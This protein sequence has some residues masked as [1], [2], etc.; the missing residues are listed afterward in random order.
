MTR[1]APTLALIGV[2][3]IWGSTFVVVKDAVEKMPVTD[4]LTWRFALASLAMLLIRPR[5]VARL[6]RPG[7]RAGVL[8]GLALAAGYLLQTLGLERTSPAISGFITGL[9][10]ALTPIGAAV[11]LRRPPGRTAWLAVLLAT[12]GLALLSLHGFSI[13]TGELLTLGCA[14]AFTFHIVGLGRWASSHDAFGLAVVQLLTTTLLCAVVAVPGGLAAPPDASVWGA[15]ALTA[16]AAT[17]LA[18]VVQTWAQAHL[19]PTRAAVIMT[20]EPVFSGLFAVALAGEALGPKTLAG[21]ALVLAAMLITE[22]G[23]HPEPVVA[24]LEV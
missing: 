22:I 3:A 14:V 10:V 18:F 8:L 6:G 11:L 9:Y 7:R 15:L 20:M 1:Q 16:L 17:A 13:G 4:F 2:T 19:A 12:A 5:S 21:A 23:P 24:K